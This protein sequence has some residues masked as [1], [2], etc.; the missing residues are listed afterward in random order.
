VKPN[1]I[2]PLAACLSLAAQAPTSNNRPALAARGYLA[3]SVVDLDASA[4]WYTEKLGLRTLFYAPRTE[5]VHASAA[6]L[7]GGGLFVELVQVDG[8][9]DLSRYLPPAE[10]AAG[11]GRQFIHGLFKAGIVVDDFDQAVATLRTRGVEIVDGPVPT[12]PDQPANVTIR[13]NSGNR[14]PLLDGSFKP[15]SSR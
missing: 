11:G 9:S 5:A 8:A 6:F 3:F 4:Q 14:I 7:Q 2:L 10:I 1:R 15:P 12:K 13:D